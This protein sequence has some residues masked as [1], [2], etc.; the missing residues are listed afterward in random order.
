MRPIVGV[1]AWRRELNTFLGPEMLQTISAYYTNALIGTGMT[2]MVI[3]NAQDPAEA[4]RIVD[5]IQG[6]VLSGGDDVD[7][8]SY[9]AR[10]AG[11][12]VF[13]KTVDDFEIALVQAARA[14][15]KPV[16]A[17]CRGLQ[18]LNV[19]LGG[20]INQEV[21]S[22]GTV[23]DVIND[24]TDPAEL[25]ERRHVVHLAEDSLLV[26]LYGASEAKVNTLHHQSIEDLASDMTVE[27]R[28]E[29]GLIEAARCDGRWWALGVQWHPERMDQGHHQLFGAFR[30]A[31]E[32]A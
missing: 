14:Q 19:A 18:I 12:K 21:L 1:T 24:Q 13:D 31:I 27:A 16:L 29:D 3:P 28:S 22:E 20:T 15:G 17:I 4:G 8:S 2:P 6:L 26:G 9:K 5:H 25:N 10:P 32:D 7:P 11:S 23:H 30:Q